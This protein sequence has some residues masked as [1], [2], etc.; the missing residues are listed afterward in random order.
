MRSILVPVDFSASSRNALTYAAQLSRHMNAELILFHAYMLPTPVSEAPYVMV[1]AEEMEKDRASALQKEMEFAGTLTGK[2]AA[3]FLRLGIASDEIR[4][5]ISEKN[6]DLIIMGM[7]G[8]GG[9]EKLMGSTTT[10]VIRKIK[11]PVLVVPEQAHYQ[12]I[13][14]VLYPSD[15]S[16]KTN[17]H[18][19]DR[20]LEIL[21]AYHARLSILHI[22]LNHAGETSD[23]LMQ[24]KEMEQVFRTVTHDFQ[25]KE[26]SS[27]THGI[28]EYLATHPADLVALVAHQHSFLERLFSKSHTN[29]IVYES[30][31]PLLVLQ[32]KK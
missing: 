22:T 1:T 32:D 30:P 14:K 2:Q 5:L 28:N 26:S 10:N 6:V 18:L 4:E 25:E 15:F 3:G 13:Q 11:T 20:L 29:A 19:Y 12:P 9:L 21:D 8:S 24:K 16:Y 17:H 7:K 23:K 27:V 31:L